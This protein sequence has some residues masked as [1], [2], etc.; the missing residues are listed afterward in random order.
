MD[1]VRMWLKQFDWSLMSIVRLAIGAVVISVAIAV[2]VSVLSFALRGAMGGMGLSASL[3]GI[4]SNE[5]YGGI[6]GGLSVHRADTNVVEPMM[7]ESF[8]AG[9]VADFGYGGDNPEAYAHR[10]YSAYYKTHRFDSVCETVAALEDREY[11]LMDATNKNENWCNYSFRVATDHEDEILSLLKRLSPES[12]D[13]SSYTLEEPIE[14]S[15]EEV[16]ALTERLASQKATLAQAE[17]TFNK[18]IAQATNAGDTAT[19]S[20]VINNKINTID[21]LSQQVLATQERLARLTRSSDAVTRQIDYVDVTVSVDRVRFVDMR[22][23]GDAW[24]RELKNVADALNALAIALT[25]GL[26]AFVLKGIPAV[27]FLC[28]AIVGLAFVAR[29]VWR[30]ILRIWNW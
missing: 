19:L 5:M 15:K 25:V 4:V 28:I 18:L 27:I 6:G 2:V 21:R 30:A 22:A 26:L 11:V 8:R 24:E 13:V 3:K 7:A 17:A 20:E 1:K 12:L 29:V 9:I 14:T 23:W 10:S 16:V